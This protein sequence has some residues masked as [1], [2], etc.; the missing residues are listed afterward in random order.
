MGSIFCLIGSFWYQQNSADFDSVNILPDG[1]ILLP[2]KFSRFW[3]R[4][5]FAWWGHFITS[6]IQ[7]ILMGSICCLMG[8]FCYQQISADFDRVNI[9]PDGVIWIPEK[10]S[11]FGWGQYFA[12]WGHFIARIIQP[13]LIPVTVSR[14]WKGQY[15]AWWG[16]SNNSKNQPLNWLLWPS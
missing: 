4:Q 12:W 11:R 1:V 3:W 13:I 9:L 10:F 16:H 14:F 7:L 6:K 2:A 15:I 5:Y 8:S